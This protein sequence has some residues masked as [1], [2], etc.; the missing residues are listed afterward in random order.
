MSLRVEVD[1]STGGDFAVDTNIAN[2]FLKVV[3]SPE[4]LSRG[5][6]REKV[7][8]LNVAIFLESEFTS[9][10]S[11]RLSEPFLSEEVGVTE[12]GGEVGVQTGVG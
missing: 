7:V 9:A 12:S 2:I 11:G 6:A 1:E 10:T 8:G 5:L 4:F 3:A